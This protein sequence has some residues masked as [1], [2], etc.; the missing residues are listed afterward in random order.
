MIEI[1]ERQNKD[2]FSTIKRINNDNDL[3]KRP[4]HI[5]SANMHSVMNS[6]YAPIVLPQ[7]IKDNDTISL[8]IIP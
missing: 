3:L 7:Q 2:N 1:C 5:I 4:I 8:F 6:I